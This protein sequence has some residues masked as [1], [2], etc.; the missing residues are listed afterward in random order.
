MQEQGAQETPAAAGVVEEAE[1]R[2]GWP[3]AVVVAVAA[4][5]GAVVVAAEKGWWLVQA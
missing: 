5:K 1:A 2:Q 3:A 4:G